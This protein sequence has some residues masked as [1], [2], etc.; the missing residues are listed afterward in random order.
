MKRLR[1]LASRQARLPPLTRRLAGL[2]P[3]CRGLS[4]SAEAGAASPPAPAAVAG[5]ATLQER[6][7]SLCKR[8]GFVFPNSEIY[9]GLTGSFDFGPLGTPHHQFIN[10]FFLVKFINKFINKIPHYV[11]VVGG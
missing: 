3:L 8:R 7:V 10:L 11:W 1:P 4:T 2:G 9:G 5:G 6:V